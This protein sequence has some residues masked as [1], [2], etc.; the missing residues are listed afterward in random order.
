[1]SDEDLA[2]NAPVIVLAEAVENRA[3]LDASDPHP[4]TVTTFR[5]LD[6]LKGTSPASTFWL[7]LP[8][9]EAGDQIFQVPGRPEFAPGQHFVL[10]LFP[11]EGRRDEY[12]LTEFALSVFDVMRDPAGTLFAV[13]TQFQTGEEM[14]LSA[15]GSAPAVP[16]HIRPLEAFVAALRVAGTG[17]PLPAIERAAPN[18]PLVAARA[19][20]EALWG[21]IG[22]TENGSNN[23]FRWFWD[24]V[25]PRTPSLCRTAHRRI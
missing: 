1:M 8:G 25:H 24:R 23:L 14:I 15:D 12:G 20:R 17:R 21:N 13:R 18:G 7:V 3:R 6:V 16:D 4:Q 22:G 19:G 11:L 9:G 10:F 5:V 2:R